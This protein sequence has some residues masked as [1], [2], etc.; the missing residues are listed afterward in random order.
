MS[1]EVRRNLEALTPWAVDLA[2][3]AIKTGAVIAITRHMLPD[4]YRAGAASA[5]LFTAIEK[6]ITG[7]GHQYYNTLYL[8]GDTR[9]DEERNLN[10]FSTFAATVGSVAFVILGKR[11]LSK[12]PITLK[13]SAALAAPSVGLAVLRGTLLYFGARREGPNIYSPEKARLY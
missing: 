4:L 11:F 6:L 12:T 3:Q 7:L 2:K 5:V 9:R 8:D 13:Q 10:V 1:P